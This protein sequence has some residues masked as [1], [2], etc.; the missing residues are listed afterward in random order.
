VGQK[1]SAA[2]LGAGDVNTASPAKMNAN[3]VDRTIII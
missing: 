1:D 3:N 2:T